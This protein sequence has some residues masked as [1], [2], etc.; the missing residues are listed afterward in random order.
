MEDNQG[1]CLDSRGVYTVDRWRKLG[2]KTGNWYSVEVYLDVRETVNHAINTCLKHCILNLSRETVRL[3]N[4][5]IYNLR[6]SQRE[7]PG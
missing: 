4:V 3:L 7:V 1:G 6:V 2:E 5:D